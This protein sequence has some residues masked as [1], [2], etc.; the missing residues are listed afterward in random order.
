VKKEWFRKNQ[1]SFDEL[2]EHACP[3]CSHEFKGFYC[4]NCGQSDSEFNRPFGFVFYDFLGNFVSFDTRFLRTFRD[5]VFRPGFLTLEFFRGHRARYAPPFRVYIFLSFVL[6]LLLQLL[7]NQ[8]L[9]TALDYELADND[10]IVL[11]DSLIQENVDSL[12]VG[13][14][15]ETEDSTEIAEFKLNY[16]DL[17]NQQTIHGKL[18]NLA[19][20]L[21]EG[22]RET[23]DPVKR[24]KLLNLVHLLRS[25]ESLVSRIL[26]YLSYAF[27]VLLPVFGLLLKLFYVRQ[28]VF[29]IRHLIFSVHI[30]AFMFSLLSLVVAINL[31][32]SWEVASWS[33]WLLAFVPVYIYLA[34]RN[35]YRQPYVKTFIKFLLLGV[36]YNL[37]LQFALVCIFISALGVL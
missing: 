4:P 9:N 27:F 22:V 28:K 2:E 30:H 20:Q 34:L 23:E 15:I 35:F 33:L 17:L 31:I 16:S 37:I 36:V 1:P 14:F 26:K 6:F 8:G 10:Q 18:R 12:D 11:A 25:P 13:Q 21:E 7:T 3:N 5:L 19:D 29:Y 32:F 24:T